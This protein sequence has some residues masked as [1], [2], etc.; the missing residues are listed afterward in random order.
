[1][2]EIKIFIDPLSRMLYSSFY[3]QGLYDIYGRGNVR[4]S[5]KYFKDLDRRNESHSF[6][7][8]M[9]Y[10]IK[11]GNKIQKII[12]DFR[13][14]ISIKKNAYLWCDKYAKVNFNKALTAPSYYKKII[15]IPPSFGIRIWSLEETVRFCLLNLI[16]CA[17]NPLNGLK[18][19]LLDYISQYMR[20]PITA[21]NPVDAK[22]N[23]IFHAS[24]LWAVQNCKEKTNVLR[25]SF[26]EICRSLSDISFE[27]G[28]YVPDEVFDKEYE[29]LVFRK[30]YSIKEYIDKIKMSAVV[31]NTPAVHN[32]HGWKLGEYLAMGKAI[33][34]TPLSNEL[35]QMLCDGKDI[36]IVSNNDELKEKILTILKN[37]EYRKSLENNSQIYYSKYVAPQRVIEL[38]N[39]TFL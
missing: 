12:I 35:P 24:T 39:N 8:Y 23:Y 31:F 27:G 33:V 18:A 14:K 15:S 32:C 9:A 11:D 4:F 17:F 16:E 21:Y 10:V 30:K 38:I 7:H 6:D 22:D 1:M 29:H 36:V 34:T 37:P 28:L 20:F 19:H 2:N 3:I 5:S 26:I 25:K 13:D